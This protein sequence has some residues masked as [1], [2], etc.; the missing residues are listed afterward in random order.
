MPMTT[1]K[2]GN[3]KKE[4]DEKDQ[5][6]HYVGEY[7]CSSKCYDTLFLECIDCHQINMGAKDNLEDHQEQRCDACYNKKHGLVVV[8]LR[9]GPFRKDY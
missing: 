2:C 1:V 8:S 5:Y 3:C 4:F 6:A 7:Y 9:F